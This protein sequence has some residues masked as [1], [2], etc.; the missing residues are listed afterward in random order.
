[1]GGLNEGGVICEAVCARAGPA[2]ALSARAQ[3]ATPAAIRCRIDPVQQG[4][5]RRRSIAT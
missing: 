1:M 2:P 4:S 5:A 3:T